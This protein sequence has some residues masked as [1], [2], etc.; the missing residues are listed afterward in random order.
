VEHGVGEYVYGIHHVNP[1]D[2]A[3]SQLQQS[4]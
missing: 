1:F 2:G 3:W 4:S